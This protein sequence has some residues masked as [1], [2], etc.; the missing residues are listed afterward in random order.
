MK[1][2]GA[3][4]DFSRLSFRPAEPGDD[5]FL[6]ALYADTRKEELAVTGWE[7]SQKAAFLKAQ[8]EAQSSHYKTHYAEAE[9]KLILF[10]QQPIGRIIIYRSGQEIRLVDI[11]LV[12]EWR[13][14]GVGSYLM[15]AL[16]DEASAVGKPIRI[17]VE[18]FNPALNFYRRLGFVSIEDKGVYWFMEWKPPATSDVQL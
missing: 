14:R 6:C 18:K 11:A 4:T 15:K 1:A 2:N 7:E 3:L 10:D 5:P 17:H 13:G 8:F 9:F 16:M 12:R